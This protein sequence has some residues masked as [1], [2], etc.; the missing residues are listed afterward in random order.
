LSDETNVNLEDIK[1]T[2]E[3][4]CWLKQSKKPLILVREVIFWQI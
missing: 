1:R 4:Y 2:D 3:D